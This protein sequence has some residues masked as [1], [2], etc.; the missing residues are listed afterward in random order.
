MQS[1]THPSLRAIDLAGFFL[2]RT[3]HS[4]YPMTD[5]RLNMLLF[6]CQGHSMSRHGAPLFTDDT[7]MTRSGPV[8]GDITVTD[9]DAAMEGTWTA[10]S[11]SADQ[12]ALMYDVLLEYAEVRT[13]EMSDITS[14][15]D[16]YM[17][18]D[19]AVPLDE[20]GKAFSDRQLPN[21][22]LRMV[23]LGGELGY[24]DDRGRLILPE[25]W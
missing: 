24:R 1:D 10:E 22:L 14:L 20:I 4:P 21:H 7:F 15:F 13:D 11:L 6:L 3:G 16:Q 17:D 23:M 25:D 19:R 2:D 8:V 18:C 12:A 5:A 9:A